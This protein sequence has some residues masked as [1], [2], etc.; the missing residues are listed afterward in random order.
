MKVSK[1]GV[2][3]D[4]MSMEGIPNEDFPNE[5]FPN[6]GIAK[7]EDEGWP[8]PLSDGLHLSEEGSEMLFK[9]LEPMVVKKIQGFNHWA[10]SDWRQAGQPWQVIAQNFPR[11]KKNISKSSVT[12]SEEVGNKRRQN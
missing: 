5:E 9:K 10:S 12:S 11:P 1:D 2:T 7:D 4:G 3:N 8:Y 6:N